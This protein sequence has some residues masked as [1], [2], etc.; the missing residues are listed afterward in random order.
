MR[1]EDTAETLLA[2]FEAENE[3]TK[4][5]RPF[6][7]LR[8]PYEPMSEASR[9]AFDRLMREADIAEP[10]LVAGGASE[11]DQGVHGAEVPK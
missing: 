4:A 10:R 5:G 9:A 7:R 2:A 3:A 6:S 11:P 1:L 8:V